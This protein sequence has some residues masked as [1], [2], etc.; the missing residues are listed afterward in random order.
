MTDIKKDS[1]PRWVWSSDKDPDWECGYRLVWQGS[2]WVVGEIRIRARSRRI[3]TSGLTTGKVRAL[4][5]VAKDLKRGN[6]ARGLSGRRPLVSDKLSAHAAAIYAE[7]VNEKDPAP[8]ATLALRLGLTAIQTSRVLKRSRHKLGLLD[9]KQL[10][11][12]A[13][14]ILKSE[15]E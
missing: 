14:Q 11:D 15:G 10:T 7:L 5:E 9:G 13:R 4:V 3:P 1:T 8:V 6:V 2:G 12:R